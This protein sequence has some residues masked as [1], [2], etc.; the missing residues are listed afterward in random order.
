MTLVSWISKI[1]V[2][3]SA[4]WVDCWNT[5][6]VSLTITYTYHPIPVIKHLD[7]PFLMFSGIT[8]TTPEQEEAMLMPLR[9]DHPHAHVKVTPENFDASE[10]P[11]DLISIE[12]EVAPST[13]CLYGS[14]LRN[15]LHVKVSKH[16]DTFYQRFGSYWLKILQDLL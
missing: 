14:L 11:P 13:L 5:S 2:S 15:F 3:F 8:P 1:F 12:L 7:N 4:G 10:W 16:C 6:N 9:P